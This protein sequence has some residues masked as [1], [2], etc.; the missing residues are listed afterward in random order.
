MKAKVLNESPE[1]TIALIYE[2]GDEVVSTLE[3]FAAERSLTSSR[4][5]AI[6]AFER[7]T[8]G[9][10]DWEKKDYQRIEVDEQVEVL[11]LL[12][13]IALEGD[14]PKIHLHAVL[15]RRDGSCVGGHLLEARVRPTLE[16]LL[17]E[18]PGY[19]ARRHDPVSGLALI[20]ARG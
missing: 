14:Q 18:S 17:V 9:Y 20:S 12:G 10:F 13:D 8:L 19:L 5:S 11:S 7:A 3:R 15:G 2:A 6:G 1:Q 4:I 16:L